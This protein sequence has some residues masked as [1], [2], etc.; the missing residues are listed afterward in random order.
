VFSASQTSQR[1][2]AHQFTLSDS[3]QW[4]D[5]HEWPSYNFNDGCFAGLPRSLA[6]KWLD[7]WGEI[8]AVLAGESVNRSLLF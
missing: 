6:N 5:Y 8:K 2:T 7:S 3:N 4:L 1:Y